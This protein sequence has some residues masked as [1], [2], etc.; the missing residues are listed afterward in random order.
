MLGGSG[1]E[2]PR[3][4]P[5]SICPGGCARWGGPSCVISPSGPAEREGR[6]RKE[7]LRSVLNPPGVAGEAPCLRQLPEM[8]VLHLPGE[9]GYFW[10][11]PWGPWREGSRA[12]VSQGSAGP[13]A[14]PPRGPRCRLLPR[15]P[16]PEEP[17]LVRNVNKAETALAGQRPYA[18]SR[19]K[20]SYPAT[21]PE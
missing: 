9:L 18:N 3:E 11:C 16:A 2:E 14:G 13:G 10:A 15:A 19:R 17:Q 1:L 6:H 21:P 7:H 4:D 12:K 20:H 5:G 8:W